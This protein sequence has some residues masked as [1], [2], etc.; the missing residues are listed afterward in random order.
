MQFFTSITIQNSN[1]IHEKWVILIFWYVM[2]M[3]QNIIIIT[4][5]NLAVSL[6]KTIY[7]CIKLSTKFVMISQNRSRQNWSG[8]AKIRITRTVVRNFCWRIFEEMWSSCKVQWQPK[9]TQLIW[10]VHN[11][12]SWGCNKCPNYWALQNIH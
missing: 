5:I 12:H 2:I 7:T 3:K 6:L 11:P 8:T 9:N 10:C 1:S 4:I